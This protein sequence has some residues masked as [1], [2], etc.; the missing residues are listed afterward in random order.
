MNETKKSRE[1]GV[2]KIKLKSRRKF[3]SK[4]IIRIPHEG[5]RGEYFI[6]TISRRES[7]D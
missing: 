4:L 6:F 5:L 3:T 1:A 2:L 7:N